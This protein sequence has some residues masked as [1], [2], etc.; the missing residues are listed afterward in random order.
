MSG[1]DSLRRR[2]G[3]TRED[4]EH[5][6][7]AASINSLSLS[8]QKFGLKREIGLWGGVSFFVGVMIGE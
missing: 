6:G 8:E 1:G 7:D 5:S 3:S 2:E 4:S